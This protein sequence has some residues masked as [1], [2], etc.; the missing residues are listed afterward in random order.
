MRAS[1]KMAAAH[2]AALCTQPCAPHHCVFQIAFRCG[3]ANRI[4]LGGVVQ[5]VNRVSEVVTS[6]ADPS[7][8][9]IFGAVIDDMYEGE[10]IPH[11]P[12]S[13]LKLH[14]L[15]LCPCLTEVIP[16]VAAQLCAGL[17]GV[18]VGV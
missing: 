16:R 14:L 3:K 11:H 15:R 1:P 10:P 9:V 18:M 6:L 12:S 17:P 2:T 8:N 4:V 5:E 7:A 13:R